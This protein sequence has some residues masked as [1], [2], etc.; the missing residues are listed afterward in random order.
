MNRYHPM[1]LMVSLLP[2]TIQAGSVLDGKAL[3]D[4]WCAACHA[5]GPGH[6]GT[7][8]LKAL[9][10]DALPA[11]LEQR[12]SLVPDVIEYVV[13]N[14]RSTMPSFRKTEINDEQLNAIGAY[15]SNPKP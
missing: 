7:Q 3:Y 13:R 11:A 14:G 9:Y 8:A 15:L 5:P 10:Q 4:H 1:I 6:P 2:L 12:E